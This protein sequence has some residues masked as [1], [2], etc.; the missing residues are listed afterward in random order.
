MLRKAESPNTTRQKSP[1]QGSPPPM[2]QKQRLKL[3]FSKAAE[4]SEEREIDKAAAG[5]SFVT[6]RTGSLI[7]ALGNPN[8]AFMK[9]RMLSHNILQNQQSIQ[10]NS[11]AMF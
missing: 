1:R 2:S 11:I 8:L 3:F 6:P 4:N 10:S 7:P 9:N 5:A